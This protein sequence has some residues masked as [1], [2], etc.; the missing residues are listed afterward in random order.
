M[1]TGG[2][3]GWIAEFEAL[4]CIPCCSP[5]RSLAAITACRCRGTSRRAGSSV[6]PSGGGGVS[7]AAVRI[8]ASVE[9]VASAERLLIVAAERGYLYCGVCSAATSIV[10][11]LHL[12]CDC[13]SHNAI[14]TQY[15]QTSM[16]TTAPFSTTFNIHHDSFQ[17]PLLRIDI[18][19][20]ARPRE[21]AFRNPHH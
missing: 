1:G 16:S 3:D 4:A 7:A 18:H 21:A 8:V 12:N 14:T 19:H 9:R 2:M 20:Q 13:A 15:I 6:M 10:P 5:T 17:V 11:R